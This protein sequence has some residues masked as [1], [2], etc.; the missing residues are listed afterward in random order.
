MPPS[1]AATCPRPHL[2]HAGCG[3]RLRYAKHCP[4]H[5]PVDA[6]AITRGYEYAPGRHVV[7]E[8]NE[9]D[10]LRPA[11]DRALRLERFVEPGHI[12]PLLYA[13]RSL[14]LVPDGAAAEPAYRVL[15]A[16][17]LQRGRWGVGRMVLAHQRQ[18]VLVRPAGSGLVLQVLHYPEL[19]KACPW[20]SAAGQPA[21]AELHLAGQLI[22][23]A[24]GGFYWDGYRDETAQEVR[25][26]LEAKLQG[27][28]AVA[29]PLATVLPLMEALKQSLAAV[30]EPAQKTAA[31]PTTARSAA[32]TARRP[33]R[34]RRQRS[35]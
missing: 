6:A 30:N 34:P 16:A 9:L 35:A 32:R 31:Q 22:D 3:Q 25:S 1:A 11:R 13:G 12:E 29:E 10:A 7:V 5:G 26:L 17:L 21:G 2:V 8:P 23:A 20:S 24:S 14:Y 27:Q 4:C 15:Q 19:V 33:A 28:P 18:V